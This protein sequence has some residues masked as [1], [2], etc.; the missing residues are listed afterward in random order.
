MIVKIIIPTYNR[1]SLLL[2]CLSSAVKQEIE[3]DYKINI[4]VSDNST[5]DETEH[6]F[7]NH[8]FNNVT[9]IRRSPPLTS[10]EHFTKIFK[11]VESDYFM[12][13][14]DDDIME[15]GMISKLISQFSP[16]TVAVAGNAYLLKNNIRTN[17]LVTRSFNPNNTIVTK[18]ELLSLY[19]TENKKFAFPGYLYRSSAAKI[20]LDSYFGKY[21]DVPFLSKVIEKGSITYL[22]E[23]LYYY[24]QHEGQDSA[25]SDLI[26]KFHLLNFILNECGYLRKDK[27]IVSYRLQNIYYELWSRRA[28]GEEIMFPELFRFAKLCAKNNN[29]I[30]LL[31]IIKN[32]I[33]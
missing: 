1:L 15:V 10:F 11:E 9:Y 17:K 12:I 20:E 31:K 5:N 23:P 7:R 30:I 28:A 8:F 19:L 25:A 2:E 6:Y 21:W 22:N 16:A 18:K 3:G 32:F 27:I 13:F 14:H 29:Y 4:L 26:S 33:F 24:R